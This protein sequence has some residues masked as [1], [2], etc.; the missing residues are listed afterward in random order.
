MTDIKFL[1]HS[2][3]GVDGIFSPPDGKESRTVVCIQLWYYLGG[4]YL[5]I[6][7]GTEKKELRAWKPN[8]IPEVCWIN[9]IVNERETSHLTETIYDGH[10]YYPPIVFLTSVTEKR[11][12]L[13]GNINIPRRWWSKPTVLTFY[14]PHQRSTVENLRKLTTIS[15]AELFLSNCS[16]EFSSSAQKKA[17]DKDDEK[18]KLL[19]LVFP[20]DQ[21]N[22]NTQLKE[23][24][25][26]EEAGTSQKIQIPSRHRRAM[27]FPLCRRR[28]VEFALAQRRR[29]WSPAFIQMP[30]T[31]LNHLALYSGCFFL[32][33]YAVA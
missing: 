12:Q 24:T 23:N 22:R 32:F 33:L 25:K 18:G 13:H 3:D 2:P 11:W 7:G 28:A 10:Y 6:E 16:S 15:Q 31:V 27:S 1:H 26:K 14:N 4:K 29:H 5:W 17:D 9:G 30:S 20:L 19:L 21:S 8:D